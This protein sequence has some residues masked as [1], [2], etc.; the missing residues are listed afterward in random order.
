MRFISL[1][2]CGKEVLLATLNVRKLFQTQSELNSDRK[3]TEKGLMEE[4]QILHV[5]IYRLVDVQNSK[6]YP[7][8]HSVLSSRLVMP[9]SDIVN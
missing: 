6:E 5:Q 9:L 3:A 1:Q 7:E 4:K 8:H 2:T